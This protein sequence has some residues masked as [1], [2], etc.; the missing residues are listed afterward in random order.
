M[1]LFKP[2]RKRPETSK[3]FAG[4]EVPQL[5]QTQLHTMAASSASVA[6][7]PR[8]KRLRTE[9]QQNFKDTE[10]DASPSLAFRRSQNSIPSALANTKSKEDPRLMQIASSSNQIRNA[11]VNKIVLPSSTQPQLYGG[12]G[13]TIPIDLLSPFKK[14]SEPPPREPDVRHNGLYERVKQLQAVKDSNAADS[15]LMIALLHYVAA[16][17]KQDVKNGDTGSALNA[18]FCDKIIKQKQ[19]GESHAE[20]KQD[21]NTSLCTWISKNAKAG[22]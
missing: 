1:P 22:T 15:E 2:E 20:S 13:T 11:S 5:H 4:A 16:K 10:R 17:C 7:P 9:Q 14:Q 12:S 3:E 18:L 21:L 8:H 19:A 6:S